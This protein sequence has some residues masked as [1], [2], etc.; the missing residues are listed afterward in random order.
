MK[1]QKQKTMKRRFV[2]LLLALAMVVTMIP[3]TEVQAKGEVVDLG[4]AVREGSVVSFPDVSV[5][6]GD[7]LKIKTVLVA[8]DQGSV[9]YEGKVTPGPVMTDLE[10]NGVHKTAVWINAEGWT[11]EQVQEM[12]RK[13]TFNYVEG[14]TVDVTV[15]TNDVSGNFTDDM[16]ATL[17]YQIHQGNGHYYMYVPYDPDEYKYSEEESRKSMPTAKYTNPTW[18]QAYNSAKEFQFMGMSGYLAT[19]TSADE[20]GLLHAINNKAA[21]CGGTLLVTADDAMKR[22]SDPKRIE[23]NTLKIY[24]GSEES[25]KPIKDSA[26]DE[27]HTAHNRP[28]YYWAC[29]PEGEAG[30][31]IDPVL[32]AAAEPNHNSNTKNNVISTATLSK[33]QQEKETCVIAN[34]QNGIGLNDIKEGNYSE[35]GDN[36]LASEAARAFGYFV[37]FGGYTADNNLERTTE[38]VTLNLLTAE[39]IVYGGSYE[40]KTT[41][42]ANEQYTATITADAA[43]GYSLPVTIEVKRY[44]DTTREWD[45]LIQGRDYSW[46]QNI[47]EVV[48]SAASVTDDIKIEAVCVKQPPYNV[49]A[50]VK[51]GGYTGTTGVGVLWPN[52]GDYTLTITADIG[53]NMPEPADVEVYIAGRLVEPGDIYNYDPDSGLVTIVEKYIV[54]DIEIKA[55]C[56]P[57]E[58]DVNGTATNASFVV[59]GSNADTLDD[60]GYYNTEYT[61]TIE[62]DAG[63]EVKK[64]D[65]KITIG[66]KDL[67]PGEFDYN[68]NTGKITIPNTQMTDDVKIEVTAQ[69]KDNKLTGNVTNGTFEGK[70]PKIDETIKTGQEYTT[71]ITPGPG[72]NRPD[73]ITVT[74]GGKTLTEGTDYTYEPTTG[75][76]TIP[77]AQ[78]TGDVKIDATCTPKDLKVDGTVTGGT[79]DG[80]GTTINETTKT[81]TQYTTTIKPDEGYNLPGSVV[82]TVD[83]KTLTPATDYIYDTTTGKITI[84]GSSVT[85]DIVIKAE[86]TKKEDTVY[87]VTGDVTKGEFDGEDTVKPGEDYEATITPDDGYK[88]PDEIKVVVGG[89]ELSEDDYEW[90]P[91]TGEVSIPG[92]S[93]T[94]DI[95]ITAKCTKETYDVDHDITNGKFK[96]DSK[97]DGGEDYEATITPDDGYKLPSEITITVD[98]E[99]VDSSDYTWDPK[100]GKLTIDGDVV[101]GDILI[102]A[103]CTKTSSSGSGSGSGTSSGGSTT[104]SATPKTGDEMN[105]I[106]YAALMLLA[107]GGFAGCA[108][109]KFKNRAPKNN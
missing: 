36:Q 53:Y 95:K 64:E 55:E 107:M 68:P 56:L 20:A 58:L 22:V 75:E 49:T 19:I 84:P 35:R 46:A 42:N 70:G 52:P 69:A 77:G 47:G 65:I 96:G 5:T 66:N 59:N 44:N 40:G 50:E 6:G 109:W 89:K 3:A 45:T 10:E 80:K 71:T 8:V 106:L 15:D 74:V 99:E 83:G 28:L 81:G 2:S 1:T 88:L 91:E 62:P 78:V 72:Y 101:T 32:W 12:L 76:V 7:G 27:D 14:M 48:V 21:W 26:G 103:K 94:G 13:L 30:M 85:G 97:V 39:G 102:T 25:L 9:N 24:D 79:F 67:T 105:I 43:N 90:D 98:G 82:V 54:G 4:D 108:V 16:G 73:D 63:Y 60:K 51:N 57:K 41:I 31:T 29:G 86:C 100:T 87:K 93:V 38:T 11:T 33:A 34:Y 61:A 17:T 18:I 23:A 104:V 92:T 37:E